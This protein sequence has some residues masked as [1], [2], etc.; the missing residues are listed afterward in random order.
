MTIVGQKSIYITCWWIDKIKK[1]KIKRWWL[2]G[3]LKIKVESLFYNHIFNVSNSP[4]STQYHIAY[5]EEIIQIVDRLPN[6]KIW[7]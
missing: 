2:E 7:W 5:K 4:N 3:N 1:S 6:Y